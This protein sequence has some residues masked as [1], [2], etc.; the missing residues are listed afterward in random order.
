MLETL[1]LT[2][3]A[4]DTIDG[5]TFRYLTRL[6]ILDLSRNQLQFLPDNAF[7]GL[8]NLEEL[9]L[10]QNAITSLTERHLIHLTKLRRLVVDGNPL[11]TVPMNMPRLESFSC[12][13]CLLLDMPL[14]QNRLRCIPTFSHIIFVFFPVT[15]IC[16]STVCA[17][18]I[19]FVDWNCSN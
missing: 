19:H 3:N 18:S 9:Y 10:S 16:P 17:Q 7:Y 4:I 14:I 11:V 1:I 6:Q 2:N 12:A 8:E 13:Q 5:E 15:S